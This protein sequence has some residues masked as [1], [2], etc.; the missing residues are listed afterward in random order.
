MAAFKMAF[1]RRHKQQGMKMGI[2]VGRE[3]NKNWE[4]SVKLWY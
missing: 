1:N 2:C 3:F 4:F